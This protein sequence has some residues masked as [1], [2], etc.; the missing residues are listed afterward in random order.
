MASRSQRG[1]VV[2]SKRQRGGNRS[3]ATG[4]WYIYRNSGGR[5]APAARVRHR[6]NKING[7]KINNNTFLD[8]AAKRV[9]LGAAGAEPPECASALEHCPAR[10]VRREGPRA[11]GAGVCHCV[12][13]LPCG[14]ASAEGGARAS[15]GA[16]KAAPLASARAFVPLGPE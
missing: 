7:S 3:S 8:C 4:D 12:A 14:M 13:E 6:A 10:L 15:P 9:I 2:E 1:P 11:L 5:G 16:R